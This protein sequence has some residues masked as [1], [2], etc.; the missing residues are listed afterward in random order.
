M[1]IKLSTS[2]AGL[3]TIRSRQ[4]AIL[5]FFLLLGMV[6]ASWAA[7]I[8]SI[9]DI[10]QLDAAT[11]SL[12]LLCG[13]IGAVGSFPLA[14]W[15]TGHY[16]ARHSTLYAGLALLLSLPLLALAPGLWT[17]MAASA[18]YGAASSC[19][20]VAINALGAQAEKEAARPIMSML[21]GWFCVGTFT[22]ALVASALAGMGITPVWHF[23][24]VSALFLAPLC[25]A[26]NALPDDRPE[27][28][29]HRKI[30][31]IPH[32]HLVVLGVIGFCGAIV[33]GS[34]ADWSGIYMKDHIHASDGGA[35]LAYAG[36]AGMMLVMRMVGDRLKERYNARRVVA[37]G[38]LAAAFGM[39]IAVMA[40]G[41]APAVLGFAI[42]GAGVA[43]VFPFVFSAAGRHGSTALAAVA[44]LGYSG[45][46]I[47]PPAVG[48]LAHGWGL[49]AALALI[50]ALCLAIAVCSSR[51]QWLE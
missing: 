30:F 39:G 32:G 46:L 37:V 18:L 14:A 44:T 45:S 20:D 4:I 51:A 43:A 11:L 9:R 26:Y 6:Y 24:L 17:L 50:G 22:G 16:G 38:T 33:E 28:D 8:P 15:L 21:H 47:G 49:P 35:P 3:P 10:L 13:G 48:F 36:F 27:H 31:A 25:M 42:A 7:R 40:E 34:I 23:L 5:L 41:M 1:T 2:R 29:P 12:V 19:F